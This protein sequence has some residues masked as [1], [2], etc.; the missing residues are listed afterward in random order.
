MRKTSKILHQEKATGIV[1]VFHLS[2]TSKNPKSQTLHMT[3]VTR[4]LSEVLQTTLQL[5]FYG[6]NE[7]DKVQKKQIEIIFMFN[8]GLGWMFLDE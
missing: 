2:H 4:L 1:Q 8:Y 6:F 5:L 7:L 3:Y